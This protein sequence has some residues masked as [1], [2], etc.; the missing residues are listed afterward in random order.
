MGEVGQWGKWRNVSL[1]LTP[2]YQ[3]NLSSS[4]LSSGFNQAVVSQFTAFPPVHASPGQRQRKW[5]LWGPL[6]RPFP[7]LLP[8]G[9]RRLDFASEVPRRPTP[10]RPSSAPQWRPTGHRHSLLAPHLRLPFPLLTLP[11]YLTLWPLC[12][13]RRAGISCFASLAPLLPPLPP[14]P[15]SLVPLS[16][17]LLPPPTPSPAHP[18]PR[19][20]TPSRLRGELLRLG[21]KGR[22]GA[23]G[24]SAA[25]TTVQEVWSSMAR[26][27]AFSAGALWLWSILPCLLVLRAE[28]GQQPEES[29]YLWI[30]AH[31]ARV[32]IGKVSRELLL[33]PKCLGLHSLQLFY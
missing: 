19:G 33:L 31:Q 29:L 25:R 28:V 10:A 8:S 21:D 16:P 18:E 12:L 30:D 13:L 5:R 14:A 23:G 2:G 7:R 6:E 22:V 4:L 9:A 26:K 27:S 11:L 24:V 15:P 3:W 17:V 32:L 20:Y 1:H